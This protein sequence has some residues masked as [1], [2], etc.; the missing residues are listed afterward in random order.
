MGDTKTY[1]IKAIDSA[2]FY[3]DFNNA[4]IAIQNTQITSVIHQ[5]SDY[6]EL[7]SRI[8]EKRITLLKWAFSVSLK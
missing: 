6:G 8:E 1:N 5:S 3:G 2:Q 4:E 7:L